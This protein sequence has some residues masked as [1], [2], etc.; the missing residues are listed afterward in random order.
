MCSMAAEYELAAD[1]DSVLRR[2]FESRYP[3]I[4]GMLEAARAQTASDAQGYVELG[5]C[6][7]ERDG[8][9]EVNSAVGRGGFALLNRPQQGAVCLEG[10]FRWDDMP[11]PQVD[12]VMGYTRGTVAERFV[13]VG[14]LPTRA[15]FF[16]CMEGQWATIGTLDYD[17]ALAVTDGGKAL[18]HRFKVTFDG[19]E[20]RLETT[21]GRRAEFKLD[22]YWPLQGTYAGVGTHNGVAWFRD[23][24]TNK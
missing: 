9:M 24:A 14:L 19:V 22:V 15:I 8:V 1:M 16:T 13:K 23:L 21:N 12:F 18:W 2:E 11:R 17:T 3:N 7:D 4:P 5:A 10:E 20:L 6:V